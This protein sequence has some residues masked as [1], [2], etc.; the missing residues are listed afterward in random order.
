[1]SQ[2]SPIV[3]KIPIERKGPLPLPNH[4]PPVPEFEPELLPSVLS[5]SALEIS[6]SKQ[7]PIDF[8]AVTFMTALSSLLAR[9][10][11]IRPMAS[12]GWTV[13]PNL[14]GLFIGRPAAKKSPSM[15][16]SL[17]PLD[18]LDDRAAKEHESAL[19]EYGMDQQ[20][21][22]HQ[23]KA[24]VASIQKLLK[25]SDGQSKSDAA[26]LIQEQSETEPSE[27]AC[28][29][30][31]AN[32][33]TVEKLAD[34]L[35]ANPSLLVYRDELSG[36][37]AGLE[38]HGQE[39]A[40]AFYLEA[41]SGHNSFKVDRIGRGSTRIPRAC[42]S[43]LG[44]IQPGPICSLLRESQ[45][46]SR[47]NDG[48]MQRFQLAVWPDLSRRFELIDVEPDGDNWRE[49]M[50]IFERFAALDTQAVGA[51]QE[52]EVP[53]LRFSLDA[54]TVFSRWLEAHENRLRNDDLPECMESHLGKYPSLV[55]SIALI[56]HIAEGHIGPVDLLSTQ[57]AIAWA[58]YL[59]A[60]ANR[61]YA[62]IIGA[63]FVAA[64]A[65]AKK[66]KDRALPERF[67]LRE[68]YRHGWANLSTE[69]TRIAAEVLEDFNWI[70]RQQE[71]TDG[72]T[73]VVYQVNPLIWES[74]K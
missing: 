39:S 22:S 55:P 65:L 24:N 30:Y 35:Q 12:G 46:H 69:E 18:K 60:H 31:L 57:K 45:R 43:V 9:H 25:K 14:W 66:I 5:V 15:S 62:P 2:H 21:H 29:R 64:R 23:V 42:V 56:L 11:A 48:L 4:L 58:T 20:L 74:D 67:G 59:E 27:P 73:A 32:D 13:I 37:F 33:T 17:R 38:R 6:K 47:A 26:A 19:Q 44:G 50:Q 63:D 61:I 70:E 52:S 49:T 16:E 7:A 51:N 34:L 8:A 1:M 72:R 10:I 41:W 71:S 28:T 40:R 36:F 3:R 68:V 54:Q 53:F